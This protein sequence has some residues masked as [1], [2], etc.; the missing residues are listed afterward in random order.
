MKCSFSIIFA[1]FLIIKIAHAQNNDV[2]GLW[3][4][5]EQGYIVKISKVGNSLNGRIVWLKN[6]AGPNGDP[7]LD[8]NNPN[9]K[10]RR[11]PLKGNKILTDFTY[12]NSAE[13]WEGGT[14]YDFTKG[15]YYQ[16]KIK[17]QN[18]KIE[19]MYSDKGQN[20][21]KIVLTKAD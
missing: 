15:K 9:E 4:N 7:V 6:E 18:E 12:N 3:K 8:S 2:L 5:N 11:L 21:N 14:F 20:H 13:I 17:M 10:M 19:L 1:F 16:S